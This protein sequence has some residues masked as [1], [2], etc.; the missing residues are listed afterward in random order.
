MVD[1]NFKLKLKD[2]GINDCELSPGWSYYVNEEKF[3]QHI[4]AH[5][6]AHGDVVEVSVHYVTDVSRLNNK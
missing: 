4:A 5:T 2:R 6:A 1:A 3:Q